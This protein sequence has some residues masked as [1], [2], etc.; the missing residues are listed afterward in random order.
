MRA[1][2]PLSFAMLVVPII[3]GM[4]ACT[5]TETPM[6]TAPETA[7][8][9]GE[10]SAPAVQVMATTPP[11]PRFLLEHD[12]V[13]AQTVE[14][15]RPVVDAGAQR[16]EAFFGEHFA[17][18]YRL[19]VLPD[20]AAFDRSFPPEWGMGETQCWMVATGVANA[21]RMLSPRVWATQACEHD[22]ADAV[23]VQGI[24][25]HEL[26]HVFH[27][28]HNPTRDGTGLEAIG[29]FVEGLAVYVSGQ[30]DEGHQLT[31]AEALAVG[32]GPTQ[33]EDGWSGRYR[34]GVSG[35]LVAFVDETWG[36]DALRDLL[37]V[38]SEQ[39]LLARLG[40]TEAELL[41]GW[42]ASVAP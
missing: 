32:A 11:T 26:V 15:L 35:S 24:V 21:L 1:L 36:R 13:D 42:R 27:M 38:T 17:E 37:T 23:H 28:Q 18:T 30:L 14:A 2:R 16:V 33:L 40:T 8:A 4:T 19:E 7:E 41:D 34:Y 31:A 22:P 29:W 10:P 12:A 3:T 25:T 39:Q 6:A 9:P 5:S 20:R